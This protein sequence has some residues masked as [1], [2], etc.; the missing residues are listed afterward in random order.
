[1]INLAAANAGD[2]H[3]K[4]VRKSQYRF[5]EISHG[6]LTMYVILGL[7]TTGKEQLSSVNHS[8]EALITDSK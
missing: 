1:M 3:Y 6:V 5:D 8:I 7:L 4:I 2:L